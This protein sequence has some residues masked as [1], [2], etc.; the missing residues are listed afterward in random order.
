MHMIAHQDVR[1]DD[2][3]AVANEK[4]EQP[5]VVMPVLIIDEHGAAIH[6]AVGDVQRNSRQF[7]TWS[8]R[9]GHPAKV[10]ASIKTCTRS[11][12]RI[13]TPALVGQMLRLNCLRPLFCGNRL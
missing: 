1:M 2:K 9:H 6:A 4:S 5:Q 3:R 13:P 11:R 12:Y 8:A 10:P 7:E